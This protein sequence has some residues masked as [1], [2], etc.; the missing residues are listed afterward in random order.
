MASEFKPN[1]SLLSK[2]YEV[3]E[4][5]TELCHLGKDTPFARITGLFM[6]IL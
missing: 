6:A 1:Y 2:D 4:V 5:M 3:A